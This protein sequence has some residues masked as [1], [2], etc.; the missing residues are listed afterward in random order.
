MTPA[1]GQDSGAF[2]LDDW[3]ITHPTS[4]RVQ[5]ARLHD[6]QGQ[7]HRSSQTASETRGKYASPIPKLITTYPYQ[8]T[9][10]VRGN[11]KPFRP[12]VWEDVMMYPE[13]SRSYPTPE[14]ARNLQVAYVPI[15]GPTSQEPLSSMP[16]PSK[17]RTRKVAMNLV[18]CFCCRLDM[19][20]VE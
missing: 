12:R 17:P 5:G 2:E 4:K 9:T 7:E 11:G 20:A 19:E 15:R 6:E 1:R 13:D 16:R 18:D 3:H 14:S 10:K 8:P